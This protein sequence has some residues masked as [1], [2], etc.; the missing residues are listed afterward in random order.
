MQLG[1]LAVEL[2]QLLCEAGVPEARTEAR[3]IINRILNTDTGTLL[4]HPETEVSDEQHS[5][6]MDIISRR[7]EREPL[8]YI[9]GE[10]SFM[11]LDFVVEPNV[12]I[13]RPDTEILVETALGELHDGMRILDLCTG[14]GCV[15]ISLLNYSN[16]CAG[17]AVDI[18]TFAC[19]LAQKNA[20]RILKT[21]SAQNQNFT[22]LQSDLYDKV[23][24]R[25]DL[26]VS[27]P[28]YINSEVVDTLE[29][30]VKKYEPRLALDGGMDG[31]DLIR[32]IIDGA[33]EYLLPGGYLMMEIGYDQGPSVSKLML[34]AGLSSVRVEQ[35]YAGLDR[36]VVGRKG[37]LL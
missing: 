18:S 21:D 37:I 15:L 32:R 3:V 2:E 35:D 25:F 6:I 16:E 13:P 4:S 27:N 24:G 28:P 19:E 20:N 26:I 12:L 30:E 5:C 22:I 11:G 9:L 17:V 34:E 36:V 33:E 10:W 23:E 29:P 8:Q 31:L 7:R 14:T 1:K